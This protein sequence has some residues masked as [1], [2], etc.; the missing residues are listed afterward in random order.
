MASYSTDTLTALIDHS[1][2]DRLA[3]RA[4]AERMRRMAAVRWCDTQA[5]TSRRVQMLTDALGHV[6]GY[7]RVA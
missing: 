3:T 5:V 2:S 7:G 6:D 1:R 4:R